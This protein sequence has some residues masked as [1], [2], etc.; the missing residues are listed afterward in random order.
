MSVFQKAL[1]G[2]IPGAAAMAFQVSTL[3]W[4]RT[5]VNYQYRHGTSTT[6]AFQTLYRDGGI[7]R[8]YRGYTAAMVQAPLS[9]FGDTA[10]NMGVLAWFQQSHYHTTPMAVQT[11]VAST[12]AAG[13]RILLMPLDTMKTTLQVEGAHGRALLREKIQQQGISALYH[14]SLAASA[15]TFVGHYP[16]FVTYNYL[17]SRLS[18][19]L[20]TDNHTRLLRNAFIG[21]VSAAASDICSNALRVIKTT[22]QTASS[23]SYPTIVR[24]IVEKEGLL[25]LFGRGLK[26]KLL[27]NGV[28]GM[29][30]SV[31]WN[32]GQDLDKKPQV[33][34]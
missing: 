28:Q 14:G 13:F 3:M 5:L 9:R 1:D 7:R 23:A 15:A 17:Q 20:P 16:W 8:F 33:F 25:G 18:R 24:S 11:A 21:F 2:G 22:R 29:L 32:L 6:Q 34:K 31:C 26:T 30:F 19:P 4:L 12:V 27:T 10:A